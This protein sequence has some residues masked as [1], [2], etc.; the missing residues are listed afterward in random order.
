MD[1][2][3]STARTCTDM[4]Y[5]LTNMHGHARTPARTRHGLTR[6]ARTCTNINWTCTDMHGP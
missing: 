4:T 1:L 2:T 5:M 6:M 3:R